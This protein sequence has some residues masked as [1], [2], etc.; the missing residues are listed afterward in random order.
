MAQGNRIDLEL[1]E[2]CVQALL[3]EAQRL[4]LSPEEVARR[5]VSAWLGEMIDEQPVPRVAA[6]R[7]GI[8]PAR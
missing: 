8:A 7:L 4:G 2:R 1:D 6:G 3:A 5:A